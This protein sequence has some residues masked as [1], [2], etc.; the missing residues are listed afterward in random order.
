M[1][2]KRFSIWVEESQANVEDYKF[3]FNFNSTDMNLSYKLDV[4]SLHSALS[5]SVD[6]YKRPPNDI[7]IKA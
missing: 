7:D 2:K 6:L 3:T 4:L 1:F 5:S